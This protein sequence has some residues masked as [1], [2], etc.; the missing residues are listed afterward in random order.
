LESHP[1]VIHLSI[2]QE[3]QKRLRSESMDDT[4][5]YE[6]SDMDKMGMRK[7]VR[8]FIFY[9][10]QP[11]IVLDDLISS[12]M[13]G[14]KNATHE[15]P[16]MAGNLQVD[17]SGKAYIMTPPGSQVV[18]NIRRFESTEHKSLSALTAD[19]FNPDDLDFIQLLPE[20]QTGKNPVCSL[21]LSLIEGGLILSLRMNH[22]AGDWASIDTFLSLVCQSSKAYQEGLDM[23]TYTP[24]LNR[25]PYNTPESDLTM[26][27]TELSEKLPMFYITDMSQ[28]QP[29][30]PTASQSGI[31]KISGPSIQRLKA[32]CTPFLSG[33]NYI[34]SYDCISGLIWTAITRARLHLHPEKSTSPSRFVHPL[35][36]RTRDPENETSK[37]YFG[38]AVIAAQAGPL[39]A[40]EL[41][42]GG[43][44][45]LAL[46]A[47]SIRQSIY[48]VNMSSVKAMTT[49]IASLSPG[50]TIGSRADFA[51]M[52]WLMN[53][54]Y[55]GSA[56]KYDIGGAA[57]PVAVRLPPSMARA[58]LILPNLSRGGTRVFE[59]H[60]EVATE[61]HELLRKDEE[62]LK[63]FEVVA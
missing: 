6:L 28:I 59:V 35:D 60:V 50:E 26:S 11:S 3:I 2:N 4:I 37:Q 15:L 31:Y 18:V 33:V 48:T 42:S 5:K 52:D 14:V 30:P 62:F 43:D 21:Q 12:I 55:S 44:R 32:Q 17:D 38:N 20:E 13:E 25:V 63:Y 16:F 19:G 53:T 24:D 40:Q 23:P 27:K 58:S 56:E 7:T 47:S 46:A 45:S 22:A 41:V 61:E 1:S 34:T 39:T 10:L 57:V 51:D 8:L 54:W 49:L 36:V 29:K 9:E